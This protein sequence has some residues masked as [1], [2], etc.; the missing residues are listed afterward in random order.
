MDAETATDVN[1]HL[2]LAFDHLREAIMIAIAGHAVTQGGAMERLEKF[3]GSGGD[4]NTLTEGLFDDGPFSVKASE[5][6]RE[7]EDEPLTPT[8]LVQA[9]EDL[10]AIIAKDPET[11]LDTAFAPEEVEEE[12]DEFSGLFDDIDEE[13]EDDDP[14]DAPAAF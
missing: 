10:G 5:P 1:E 3:I 2:G 7:Y 8:E 6:V 11:G 14:S 4:V 12:D 13:E 9:A